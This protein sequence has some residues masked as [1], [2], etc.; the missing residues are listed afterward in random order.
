MVL[1]TSKIF[2]K[3]VVVN[4]LENLKRYA[5]GSVAIEIQRIYRGFAARKRC[6]MARECRV[7]H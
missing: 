6:R 4:L 1:G 7:V 3:E 2:L 5:H